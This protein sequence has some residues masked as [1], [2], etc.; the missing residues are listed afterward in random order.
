MCC[1]RFATLQ[2][3]R[4]YQGKAERCCL[5]LGLMAKSS[6][7][8]SLFPPRCSGALRLQE[9]GPW[10][11]RDMLGLEHFAQP[12]L[13]FLLGEEN[14]VQPW[15]CQG[16]KLLFPGGSCCTPASQWRPRPHHLDYA[17][18]SCLAQ[19]TS[20]PL[21]SLCWFLRCFLTFSKV[22]L[23]HFTRKL[24]KMLCM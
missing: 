19:P 20:A 16:P 9:A 23:H 22:T 2:L 17:G 12:N 6:C 24:P 5:C 10:W 8:L 1:W 13:V 15:F 11:E 4:H 14:D 7:L 3:R 18:S 21:V